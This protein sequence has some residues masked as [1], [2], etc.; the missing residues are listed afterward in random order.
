MN[1]TEAL[2]KKVEKL[3]RKTNI[4]LLVTGLAVGA[5][6]VQTVMQQRVFDQMLEVLDLCNDEIEMLGDFMDDVRKVVDNV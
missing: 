5:L 1:E 2:E 6:A 4:C 3:N